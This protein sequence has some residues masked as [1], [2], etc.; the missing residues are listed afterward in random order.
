MIKHAFLL[1]AHNEPAVLQVL[2]RLLDDPRN[3]IFLHVD[4]RAH[5]LYA[6][7]EKLQLQHATLH[8]LTSRMEVYWGDI[9]QVEVEYRLFEEAFVHGPYAYYHLMS[10]VDLPIKTQDEIHA[11][12]NRH[13]GKEFVGY[14]LDANHKRDVMRKVC[15]YH[16]YT[17]Y[18]KGG[19][20]WKHNGCALIRNTSLALQKVLPLRRNRHL[21]FRKGYNWVSITNDFCAYLLQRKEEVFRRF[22]HTLC[23]DEIFLHTV[24][25]NSP[26][27]DAVFSYDDPSYGSMR[28]IDWKRGKHGNPYVWREEDVDALMASPCMFARKF[29]EK[30]MEAVSRID[31]A[32]NN[33]KTD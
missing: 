17:K 32:L 25:W 33:K 24:L 14:W 20:R 7:V 16:L 26:F 15:R 18:S 27:K 5:S 11:F 31:E 8:L 10:G 19:P 1:I 3:D 2:L 6:A 9:S 12:F 13:A 28:A 30:Y 23:P 4:K 29:S 21:E 22:K